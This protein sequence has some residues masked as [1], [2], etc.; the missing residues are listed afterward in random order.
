MLRKAA[1]RTQEAL[2]TTIGQLIESFSHEEC[3]NYIRNSG[4]A[5]D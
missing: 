4:Y 5:F 3:R 1:S 2:W